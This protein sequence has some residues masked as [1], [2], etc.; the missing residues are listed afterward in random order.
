MQIAGPGG[1]NYT[2]QASTNLMAWENVF[3]TNPV[4]LPL[5]WTDDSTTNFSRRFYRVLL[6]P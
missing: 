1:W 6:G 2:V 5:S 3:T 4:A